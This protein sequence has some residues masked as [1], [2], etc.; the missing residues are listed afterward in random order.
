MESSDKWSNDEELM[1]PSPAKVGKTKAGGRSKK[2][3][4]SNGS[5]DSDFG[6]TVAKEKS[7][8]SSS[9][10]KPPAAKKAKIVKPKTTP[11]KKTKKNAFGDSSEDASGS[12]TNFDI[13][14]V[15]PARDR[16]GRT[17]TVS[18]YNFG[19]DSDEFE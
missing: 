12:D 6:S 15:G 3:F 17:K 13:S 10:D 8:K 1:K 19:S 14:D 16:P 4:A 18:K 11:K 2:L 7:K 9:S 5:D